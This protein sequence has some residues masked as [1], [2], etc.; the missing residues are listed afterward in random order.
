MAGAELEHGVALVA[1]GFE[2]VAETFQRNLTDRGDVGA[3][4]TAYLDGTP[5]IDVWGGLADRERR[6]PWRSDTL[7]G[8]FSGTKGLVAACLLLMIDRGLLD[9]ETPVWAYWP[10][11]RA[12]GKDGILVR[13]VV[14]HQG[15]LPGLSTAVTP[16]EATDGVRMAQLLANQRAI[17]AP[18]AS[19]YYHAL[20]F[21][22]LCGELI[23]RVDG[24]SVGRVLREEIAEP[25]GLDA[26]IGLPA[27]HEPRVAAHERS[28][29]FGAQRRNLQARLERDPIAWSIWS[30]PPRFS[31]DGQLPANAPYWRAAEIPGSSGVAN[32]RSMAR[33]YGCLARGGEINGVRLFAPATVELASMCLSRGFEPYLERPC[34]FSVGFALQTEVEPFGPVADAYGHPGAGGSVHG[35]WPQLKT[36]F[37]YVTNTLRDSSM[38]DPRATALLRALHAALPSPA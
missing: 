33:L 29:G 24:R 14:S 9:L 11:F 25:L 17:S 31:T 30:N 23:R 20:T 16:E 36:G 4:F 1:P 18:G 13:H 22:W 27:E 12:H 37:S 26:W 35:A 38:T 28:T 10:E 2:P 8:L 7:A 15:G 32:A 19:L 3:A 6:R 21:G 34:A 5:V